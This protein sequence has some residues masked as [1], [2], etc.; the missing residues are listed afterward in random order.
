MVKDVETLTRIA[1]T[2][3][4]ADIADRWLAVV[5]PSNDDISVASR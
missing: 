3:L 5:K 4:E 2:H 1:R